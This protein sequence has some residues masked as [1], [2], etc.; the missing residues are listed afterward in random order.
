MV[1][2][3]EPKTFLRWHRWSLQAGQRY[4]GFK[5]WDF[6]KHERVEILTWI[7]VIIIGDLIFDEFE[8]GNLNFIF[9]RGLTKLCLR[10]ILTV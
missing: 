7:Y 9:Q 3:F 4:P 8:N 1:L 2:I 10:H 6:D 5:I